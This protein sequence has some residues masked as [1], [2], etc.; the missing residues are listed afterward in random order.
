MGVGVFWM[1]DAK[2]VIIDKEAVYGEWSRD[3]PYGFAGIVY[4]DDFQ[5]RYQDFEDELR[6]LLPASYEPVE[7][8]WRDMAFVIAANRFYEV[9]LNDW[10]T[11]FYLSMALR[12]GFDTESGFHTLAVA[13]HAGAALAIF[14]RIARFYSLRV[15]T[16]SYTT[17]PYD[18]F[19]TER[20]AA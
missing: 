4:E 5:I 14:Q 20:S 10:E 18:P 9:C 3:Y 12:P 13:N 17:G 1:A 8:R 6:E 11:D 15:R 16:G 7:N 19:L 2:T